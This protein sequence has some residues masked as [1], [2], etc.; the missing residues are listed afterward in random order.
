MTAVLDTSTASPAQ[1]LGA[2][3]RNPNVSAVGGGLAM[4][5]M[6]SKGGAMLP[7]QSPA[8][9]LGRSTTPKPRSG[10]TPKVDMKDDASVSIFCAQSESEKGTGL[11]S[12]DTS[13]HS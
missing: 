5:R 11:I 6:A 9:G 8:Q 4:A 10:L 1:M 12:I 13:P 7:P 2:S 3:P